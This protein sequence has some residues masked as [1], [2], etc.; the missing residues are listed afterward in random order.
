MP[1]P[2]MRKPSE[3]LWVWIGAESHSV[4]PDGYLAWRSVDWP[5]DPVQALT[6]ALGQVSSAA[7]WYPLPDSADS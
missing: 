6:S 3:R 4:G 7:R 2:P 1:G 5:D